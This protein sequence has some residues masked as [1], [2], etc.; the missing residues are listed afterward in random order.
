MKSERCTRQGPPV[1]KANLLEILPAPGGLNLC[2]AHK[3][4]QPQ[5][6]LALR[7]LCVMYGLGECFQVN[8]RGRD[9]GRDRKLVC[10]GSRITRPPWRIFFMDEEN[11]ANRDDAP[12]EARM[13]A[14]STYKKTASHFWCGQF[15][16]MSGYLVW[17]VILLGQKAHS[18]LG[19]H[20]SR[21]YALRGGSVRGLNPAGYNPSRILV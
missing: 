14:P 9:G 3:E 17:T 1:S 4:T 12:A 18:C 16:C 11:G 13:I 21:K 6:K 20:P 15:S 5:T 8:R 2:K 10:R 19:W 7:R